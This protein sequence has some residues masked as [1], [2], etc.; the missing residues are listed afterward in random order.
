MHMCRDQNSTL[1]YKSFWTV[2][3]QT[4]CIEFVARNDSRED[5]QSILH[6]C[7]EMHIIVLI[8]AHI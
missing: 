6:K 2:C 5:T 3:Y 8:D 7:I 4:K 1:V